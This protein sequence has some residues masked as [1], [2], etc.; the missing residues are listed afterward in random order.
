MHNLNLKKG[1]ELDIT[2]ETIKNKRDNSKNY[3]FF[4][5]KAIIGFVTPLKKRNASLQS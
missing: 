5:K 3:I 2:S 1:H 4:F